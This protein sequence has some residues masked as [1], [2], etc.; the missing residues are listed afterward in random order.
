MLNHQIKSSSPLLDK[1][2]SLVQKGYATQGLLVY[3]RK[4]IKTPPW[5]IK[6]WDF[7]QVSN[8]D[9]CLQLTIG[10]VSYAGSI[11]VSLIDW[12]TNRT[13][14]VTKLLPLPFNRLG[15]PASAET[16]D[17]IYKS[18]LIDI[19]FLVFEGGRRLICQT[20]DKQ[21][22]PMDIDV[23]LMQPDLA[24]MVIATPFDD[25]P[26][27]F[28]Y[29]HKINCMPAEGMVSVGDKKYPFEPDTAFGLLDWGRGVWPFSHEWFWGNGSGIINGKRFGFNIG[30]GFGNTETATENMLFYDGTAHKLNQVHVDLLAGGYMAKKKFTSDDGRFE[31]EFTPIYDHF[32]STKKLFVDNCC[33]QVFGKFSGTAVLD[34][35]TILEVHDLLAFMEHAVNNW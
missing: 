25:N 24:S 16:G 13:Y 1:R 11:S 31:M 8:N 27:Y 10:H 22:P 17:L 5:R 35:G 19:E 7:Y 29:N 6:E 4:Q 26:R 23:H 30:F 28:Y 34:D 33:H 20:R 21:G 18:N 14:N 32:T 3:N 9:Y 15:M 2:G 12:N